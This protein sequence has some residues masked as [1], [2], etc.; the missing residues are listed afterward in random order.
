MISQIPTP[1]APLV[2][3][4]NASGRITVPWFQFLL[5]LYQTLGPPGGG[6]APGDADYVVVAA[7][8]DLPNAR[9]A[10]DSPTVTVDLT[11]P[12]IIRWHAVSSG[13]SWVPLSLGVEPLTFVSDGAGQPI[14]VAFTP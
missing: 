8:P 10:T 5:G 14:F 13:T 3:P 12:G 6:T 1:S 2:E 9:V 4:G 11:V 7:D